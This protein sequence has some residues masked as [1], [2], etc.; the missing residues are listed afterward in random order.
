MATHNTFGSAA[1]EL[2]ARLLERDG[3]TILHRNWRFRHKE[4]DLIVCRNGVVAFVEVRA[5]RSAGHG[6]PIETIGWRKRR[7]IETAA[8][9]WLARHGRPGQA[10]RFDVVTVLD[11]SGRGGSSA[12]VDHVADAWRT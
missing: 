12:V 1:E 7:E 2:A 4:I 5:R 8:R 6:H 10:Y 3:W 11:P 9:A